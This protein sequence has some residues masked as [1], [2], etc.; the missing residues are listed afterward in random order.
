MGIT[1]S[2]LVKPGGFNAMQCLTNPGL[3]DDSISSLALFRA[4][5]KLMRACA[6][7]DF[8]LS[9]FHTPSSKRLKRQLSAAINLVKFREERI[10]MYRELNGQVS[11]VRLP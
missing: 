11:F 5:S 8:G 1:P 9:D 2:D 7:M 4:V 10:Q 3:Y 6:I